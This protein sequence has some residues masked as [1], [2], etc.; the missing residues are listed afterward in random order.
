MTRKSYI[1]VN[2]FFILLISGIFLYCYLLDSLTQPVVCVHQ[3]YLNTSCPSCG[4]TRSISSLLHNE[5][6]AAMKWNKYGWQ[7]FLFFLIQ[8]GMRFLCLLTAISGKKNLKVTLKIDWILTSLLF[9]LCFYPFIAS[10]FYL[11]Y[12]MIFTGNVNL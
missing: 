9:L 7:I 8:L 3:E 1:L 11:F 6:A 12:K 10:T 5:A 2:I 4:L